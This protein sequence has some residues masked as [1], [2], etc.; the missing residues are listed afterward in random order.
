MKNYWPF[1]ILLLSGCQPS[2]DKQPRVDVYEPSTFFADK[3]GNRMPVP[4]TYTHR[5]LKD[6]DKTRLSLKV[7]RSLLERGQ[8][9]YEIYCMVCHGIL[10]DGEG[11]V[12]MRGFSHPPSYHTDYLRSAN[13]AHF[14]DVITN[15]KGLMTRLGDR[16]EP[17]DRWAII[18][19]IRSLQLS[20]N[21]DIKFLTPKDMKQLEAKK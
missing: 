14:Y 21:A 18:A 3:S 19:Y 6:E 2:L 20:Q 17:R 15:G 4:D 12:T 7:D 11:I 10:G 9:R 1:F 16:I 5:F 8:E 13:S